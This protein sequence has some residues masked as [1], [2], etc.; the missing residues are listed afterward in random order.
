MA[1]IYIHTPLFRFPLLSGSSVVVLLD[2]VVV[3]MEE[4][5]D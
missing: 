4:V 1:L 3:E 5:E 2:V